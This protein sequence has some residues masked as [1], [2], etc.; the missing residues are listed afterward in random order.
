MGINHSMN[1]VQVDTV[2]TKFE[3]TTDAI[4]GIESK[5]MRVNEHVIRAQAQRAEIE[6][7][8]EAATS[9]MDG[10]TESV[11]SKSEIA[12]DYFLRTLDTF[13]DLIESFEVSIS[14][15][16]LL[17]APREVQRELGPLLMPAIVLVI[18]VTIS[19]CVFGFLLAADVELAGTFT[20]SHEGPEGTTEGE[21]T[22][23]LNLFAIFHV[24]LIGIAVAYLTFEAAK[25]ACAGRKMYRRVKIDRAAML[26]EESEEEGEGADEPAEGQGEPA[27]PGSPAGSQKSYFSYA[28]P[29]KKRR[30][31]SNSKV[32]HQRSNR[33]NGSTPIASMLRTV[34]QRAVNNTGEVIGVHKLIRLG[35][36]RP[37]ALIRSDDPSSSGRGT[38]SSG[39]GA[40]MPVPGPA[41]RPAFGPSAPFKDGHGMQPPTG[42]LGDTD[43]LAGGGGSL[44]AGEGIRAGGGSARSNTGSVGPSSGDAEPPDHK[45]SWIL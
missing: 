17:N 5:V 23:I 12:V 43:S 31:N 28:S 13:A 8:A 22:N 21:P 44:H 25:Q 35:T 32:G 24:V 36:F 34:K 45:G 15:L 4:K 26:Q 7:Q 10:L 27:S 33:S 38:S 20:L 9:L 40:A 18:T 41:S 19:N 42:C 6:K 37:E 3:A 16:G 1:K 14:D 29:N 2:L 11:N 30:P 39:G